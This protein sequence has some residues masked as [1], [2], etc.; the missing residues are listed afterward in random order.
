MR[1]LVL[2]HF[3]PPSVLALKDVPTPAAAADHILVRVAAAGINP[4][5]VKNVQGF[6]P[7]T[8]LP[9]V[10]GRDF[11]G[12]VVDGPRELIGAEVWGS[13]GDI[14]FTR[15]GS[16][17]EF[18][19]L[20]RGAFQRKPAR[21]SFAEAAAA[22]VPFITAWSALIEAAQLKPGETVVVTG[23]NGAV[24]SAALQ[25]A[26]WQGAR[27]IAVVRSASLEPAVRALG[28][29]DVIL[30][31][32]VPMHEHVLAQ[33]GGAQVVF[34]TVGGPLF[35]TALMS[36]ALRGRLVTIVS[37]GEARVSFNLRDFYHQEARL[38]GVDTMKLN[39]VAC[40]ALFARMTPLFERGYLTAPKVAATYALDDAI[41]AYEQVGQ[42][43]RVVL[44]FDA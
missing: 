24:G 16:H 32:E 6:F 25:I 21:L 20:P 1:A 5:D 7:S 4:S 39:A 29:D 13:G 8:T 38:M 30:L 34:D 18:L 11:A 26:R 27:V 23:A 42:P 14:G 22:G 43:G 31:G 40:A 10:P 36:L 3:G 19:L 17:A 41:S 15:D 33:T 44:D 37:T 35:E 2:D 28:A 9:R 12:T